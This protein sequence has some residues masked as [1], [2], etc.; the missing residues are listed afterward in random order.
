MGLCWV[1]CR[2]RSIN[3]TEPETLLLT[4]ASLK[5]E[6][7]Y[8]FRVVAYNELGPGESSESIRLTTKQE[9][10]FHPAP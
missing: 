10:K 6:Q 5:P 3:V 2:E 8:T 1:L 4:V 7:T 9:R